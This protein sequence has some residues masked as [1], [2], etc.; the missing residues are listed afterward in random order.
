[1]EKMTKHLK[2]TVLHNPRCVM[3]LQKFK[4]NRKKYRLGI[5]LITGHI[6]L[7]YHL[8]KINLADTKI[9]TNCEMETEDVEH[10]LGKCGKLYNLR[11]QYFDTHFENLET[12]FANNNISKIINF[13][14]KTLRLD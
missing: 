2:R 3:E 8:H 9:C 12:I 6:G 11:Q 14:I 1:M 13:T 4:N 10:L 7:N 5:Q